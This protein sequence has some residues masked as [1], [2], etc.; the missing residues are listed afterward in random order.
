M[1]QGSPLRS[2][3]NYVQYCYSYVPE[4]YPGGGGWSLLVHSLGSLYEDY[5][6]LHNIWTT[7]NVALPL[8]RY[9]GC[10][11][12]FF[13]DEYTDYIVTYD[14]CWP[15]VDTPLTHAD[16]CPQRMLQKKHKIIIPSRYTQRKRKPYKKVRVKPPSQM[17]NRWYFQRDICNTPLVMLTATAVSLTKPFCD[18]KAKS[19]NISVW[20]LNPHRYRNPNFQNPPITNGYSPFQA[21]NIENRPNMYLWGCHNPITQKKQLQLAIPLCNT[22]DNRLG[23][24]LSELN[25]NGNDF[26][27]NN[28]FENWGN[29]F[30]HSNF[31]SSDIFLYQSI[32]GPTSETAKKWLTPDYTTSNQS[33]SDMTLLVGPNLYRCR[34]NP[35][36]DTGE[37]NKAY[38]ISNSSATSLE[39]P[40]NE[41]LIIEGFPLPIMLW[42]WTDFIRK[43]KQTIDIDKNYL[44]VVKSPF[45]EEKLPFYVFIDDDFKDGFEPY[46]SNLDNAQQYISAYNQ[47]H[48]YPKLLFQKQSIEKI[49]RSGAGCARPTDEKYLQAQYKYKFYFKWGGCPK[50]LEKVFD[51][52][53]QSKWPTPDNITTRLEITN[54]N[55]PPQTE[56]YDWDWEEE[57]VKE[58]AVRRIQAYT[59][60][61]KQILFLTDSK[62]NPK[63]LLKKQEEET[64][65]NEE[66]TTL[67]LQLHRL[68]QQ[69]QLLQLQVQSKLCN[70]NL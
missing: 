54:P 45:F 43:L 16:S 35:E 39:P 14:T 7:S 63:P 58:K 26:N 68:R 33:Q 64:S 29:P 18:P 4:F 44:L 15:L 51:P 70:L 19:N 21:D 22:K 62:N 11:F 47:Q 10:E 23:V 56:L 1:F 9:L 46:T 25:K 66:E 27:Q 65:D 69:R 36:R 28:K 59:E 30:E 37:G 41:N 61:P 3:N 34:Y 50:Q 57:Y 6:H 12:T 17:L 49:C 32:H 2:S 31:H 20:C 48:W 40:S 52:C 38:L 13:Q 42:G 5:Q 67:L 53:L 24:P 55:Q 60:S 8:V